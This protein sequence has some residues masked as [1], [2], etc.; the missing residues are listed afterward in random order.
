MKLRINEALAQAKASGK[1][2]LKKELAAKLWPN[3]TALAQKTNLTNLINGATERVLPEWVRIICKET[4]CS[5]D[6][7]LGIN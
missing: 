7:L 6:Y 1:V 5:A 4:G 3:S 2:I